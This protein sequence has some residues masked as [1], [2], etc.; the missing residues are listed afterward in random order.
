MRFLLAFKF[1]IL[2][3]FYPVLCEILFKSILKIKDKIPFE[4]IFEVIS[5]DTRYFFSLEVWMTDEIVG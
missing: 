3:G 1:I 4:S 2:N 5:E